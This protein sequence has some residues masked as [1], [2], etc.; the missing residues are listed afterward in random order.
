M[1][2]ENIQPVINSEP[3]TPMADE[4]SEM[5]LISQLKTEDTDA[6]LTIDPHDVKVK[7]G[8]QN[9][10]DSIK[11]VISAWNQDE[12]TPNHLLAKRKPSRRIFESPSLQQRASLQM[13]AGANE[14]WSQA[15][16]GAKDQQIGKSI[17]QRQ[18]IEQQKQQLGESK[19]A[20]KRIEQW[21]DFSVQ[22]ALSAEETGNTWRQI[23][24]V[25]QDSSRL[26]EIDRT[27]PQNTKQGYE[28][29]VLGQTKI[30]T[31]A[32]L[33]LELNAYLHKVC[34]PREKY[35]PLVCGV[36]KNV[37]VVAL[38]AKA[39]NEQFYLSL[40]I[41]P[42]TAGPISKVLGSTSI[43][44]YGEDRDKLTEIE[45]FLYA[46]QEEANAAMS[47][48]GKSRKGTLG[49]EEEENSSEEDGEDDSPFPSYYR[50]IKTPAPLSLKTPTHIASYLPDDDVER[51]LRHVYTT[52]SENAPDTA[53]KLSPEVFSSPVPVV[54]LNDMPV[55][56]SNFSPPSIMAPLSVVTNTWFVD[57]SEV[58]GPTSGTNF[59]DYGI[60]TDA[61]VPVEI[62]K[63]QE[64]NS[65]DRLFVCATDSESILIDQNL[66]F[67]RSA[68][69]CVVEHNRAYEWIE[70]V[71]LEGW[72][73]KWPAKYSGFGKPQKRFFILKDNL[74]CYY[75]N[76]PQQE[77]DY[78]RVKILNISEDTQIEK[79]ANMFQNCLKISSANGGESVYIKVKEGSRKERAWIQAIRQSMKLQSASKCEYMYTFIY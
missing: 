16:Q 32:N 45:F 41:K 50:D 27:L 20:K 23:K 4:I 7:P 39:V 70:G 77:Q 56:A 61:I 10:A 2:S 47:P 12:E 3:N 66:K 25:L 51:V 9:K 17:S 57:E 44:F 24:D 33:S 65:S 26:H 43:A 79:V 74:L 29:F 14:L 42:T 22:N 40:C 1:D 75:D 28:T 21:K 78:Q 64:T 5:D 36:K 68:S 13:A 58:T 18:M 71:Y 54:P 11:Q 62:L 52:E 53:A 60:T 30:Y 49:E 69:K 72:L 48:F 8:V 63:V 19:V 76:K 73:Y 35:V 37:R 46:S 6:P 38:A 31:A 15:V 67:S 55:A 34:D 59:V